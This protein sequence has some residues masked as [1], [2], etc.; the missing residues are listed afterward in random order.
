[1]VAGSIPAGCARQISVEGVKFRVYSDLT[2]KAACEWIRSKMHENAPKS[3]KYAT[4]DF[5]SE[6]EDQNR[7][8]L[9]W[10]LR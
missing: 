9:K 4:S 7:T 3:D 8:T 6:Q 10:N 1:M 5:S 2:P